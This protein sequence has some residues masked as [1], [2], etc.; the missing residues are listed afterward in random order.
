[1][2][3]EQLQRIRKKLGL[4]QKAMAEEIGISYGAYQRYE[5]GQ[6]EPKGAILATVQ[7]FLA[8]HEPRKDPLANCSDFLEKLRSSPDEGGRWVVDQARKIAGAYAKS[9][10]GR[11]QPLSVFWLLDDVI[12]ILTRG[13]S[14]NFRPELSVSR[15][16][17][18]LFKKPFRDRDHFLVEQA[19]DLAAA[20]ALGCG[21]PREMDLVLEQLATGIQ[22]FATGSYPEPEPL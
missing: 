4:S 10:A 15:F 1:M 8:A 19:V 12:T 22:F 6:G 18:A 21:Q 2:I 20:W 3:S 14:P 9:P 11:E 5:Y 13:A 7:A 16:L 17:E